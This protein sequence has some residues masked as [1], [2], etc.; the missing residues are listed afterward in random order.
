ML[1]PLEATNFSCDRKMPNPGS[2][3]PFEKSS[4]CAVAQ[5]L[6]SITDRRRGI[7]IETDRV[8]FLL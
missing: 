5:A 3:R 7:Q 8:I 1:P 6:D 2:V 4:R